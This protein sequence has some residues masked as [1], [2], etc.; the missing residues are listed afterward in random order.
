MVTE[1]QGAIEQAPPGRSRWRL[2]TYV[3]DALDGAGQ[4]DQ[5]L[6]LY[7]TAAE[8]A[9]AASDWSD[10]ATITGNWANA[11]GTVAD[12]GVAKQLNLRSADAY[13]QAGNLEVSVIQREME[14][15]RIDVMR[16]QEAQVLPDIDSRLDQVRQ[17]WQRH[18]A[19]ESVV[20]APNRM[21]LGRT[22]VSALDI[23]KQANQGLE[24]WQTC[25]DLLQEAEL[26]KR[27]L[28]ESDVSLAVTH[29]N[30]YI[31]LMRL[32]QLDEAQSV[33]EN[34]LPVF[35][36]AGIASHE[37]ACLSALADVWD[38]RGE[39]AEAIALERQAL[40]V[41]S[42]L[43]DPADRA[44]SHQNLSNYLH[45]ADQTSEVAT[46]ELAAG[47]YKLVVGRGDHLET[48]RR[49]LGIHA[50]RVMAN[51]P[52]YTLPRLEDVLAQPA[53]A[54]LRQF[55]DSRGVDRDALQAAIDQM[56]EQADEQAS[57][58]DDDPLTRLP[59]ETAE[60]L[61]P[62]VDA[63][64]AG[65]DVEP[66]LAELRRQWVEAGA[67]EPEVD[68]ALNNLRTI[69]DRVRPSGDASPTEDTES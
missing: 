27:G 64:A 25:L 57:A 38:Q 54:A 50:R 43:P 26:A 53:F 34:C 37:A 60:L 52:R 7:A 61:R 41:R 32:G 45:R 15:L 30:Q 40:A 69:L 10:V 6:S 3:A 55:L 21:V 65:Q 14:A 42:T 20:E 66:M 67:D 28:G 2:R 29:F 58:A 13:R 11:A 68:A 22:L 44:I 17:W 35:R 4:A 36:S 51:G 47:V 12:L 49:N 9:E 24:R 31:S 33:L 5:A 23:A 59:P 63:A 46:Q 16:G 1:L 8:E 56:V 39:P 62:I 48:W 19:G 18:Q